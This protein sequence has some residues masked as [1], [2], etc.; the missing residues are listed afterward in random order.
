MGSNEPISSKQ[1]LS[2]IEEGQAKLYYDF[3]KRVHSYFEETIKEM[4]QY[5]QQLSPQ[6]EGRIIDEAGSY[7]QSLHNYELLQQE[8]EKLKRINENQKFQ[9]QKLKDD[10]A[11]LI[12]KATKTNTR[13]M[14]NKN[15]TDNLSSP[16]ETEPK[17]RKTRTPKNMKTT[18]TFTV[19]EGAH[20]N[21]FDPQD[22]KSMDRNEE[23]VAKENKINEENTES[24]NSQ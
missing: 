1:F 17:T 4:Q 20:E 3:G 5:L 9:I 16:D 18:K 14:K 22:H 21:E 6:N 11:Q 23:E 15:E 10:N 19:E 12:R 8:V 7:E 13:K 24:S 2:K